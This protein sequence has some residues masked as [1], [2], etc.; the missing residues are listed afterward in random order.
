MPGCGKSVMASF[1]VDNFQKDAGSEATICY[2]FFKDDNM[3][4]SN[5]IVAMSA[6]LH[7][8]YP[9]HPEL[10]NH[11]RRQLAVPGNTL[12]RI[13]SLWRMLVDSVDDDAAKPKVICL[14]DGLDECDEAS[15]KQLLALISGYFTQ[16]TVDSRP[17]KL[18]ML[19][20][21]RPDNS[22]KMTFDKQA[23]RTRMMESGID[24]P[25][26]NM[27]RLR[28]E[29][30]TDAISKDIELVVHD[31]VEDLAEQG[32]PEDLLV[33][34]ETALITRA[35]RTFLWIAL[36][37][38]LLKDKVVEGASRKEINGILRSR[39]VY[40][41]YSALLDS[42]AATM[43]AVKTRAR[44]VLSLILG[45]MR[46]LTIEELSIAL[47][48]KP[49][50]DS[51]AVLKSRPKPSRRTFQHVEYE[52]VCP[53]ENHIKALCGHFVRII[54][55]KV[56]LVHQTAREFLLDEAS[57]RN[58]FVISPGFHYED[59]SEEE[60]WDLS[61]SESEQRPRPSLADHSVTDD[62]QS[63]TL[64][65]DS[66]A[67]PA[68]Q[69]T[70]SLERCHALLLEICMTYLYMLGKPTSTASLG[71]PTDG[72]AIFLV[73]AA[74]YWMSHFHNVCRK[75]PP[76]D[77]SY[78]HGLGHPRFPG[79]LTWLE[80][81]DGMGRVPVFTGSGSVDEQQDLMIEKFALEPSQ[82]GFGGECATK[83]DFTQTYEAGGGRR[84]MLSCNPSQSQN[85]NFP[86]KADETGVVTLDFD[87][88]KRRNVN[89]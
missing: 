68:W 76:G 74:R 12:S 80:A 50:H 61:D 64:I 83:V 57:A 70:F 6:I 53:P 36:I 75:I 19:V 9:A 60:L 23:S 88:A 13:E 89:F 43:P 35:D 51:F 59:D 3:E 15:R 30:E 84:Q 62:G 71:Q 7:Q 78:Y 63:E 21:S 38:Q 54:Q 32:M 73:Y 67:E 5:A 85:L 11:A 37:L 65:G 25:S 14:L 29:D 41:I 81:Y 42:K 82:P 77:L 86:V 17:R 8:L 1:L 44:K 10:T 46:P 20:L 79:F 87:M 58:L 47:A 24:L 39:S 18:R 26:Y 49:D 56:Y 2:F 45:A 4:Q 52:M 40:S 72:V 55:G 31:A 22:I 66:P 33:D 69:H 28:G 27:I 16:P 34:V 48:I